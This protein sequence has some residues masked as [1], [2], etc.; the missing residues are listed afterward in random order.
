MS[1]LINKSAI[2]YSPLAI[3]DKFQF[4]R[5]LAVD[6]IHPSIFASTGFF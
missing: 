5:Y 3:V 4:N 2:V 1:K 6:Y